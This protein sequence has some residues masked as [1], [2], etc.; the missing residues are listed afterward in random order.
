MRR[1]LLIE[2]PYVKSID[3]E[4]EAFVKRE[5]KG[6]SPIIITSGKVNYALATLFLT[7]PTFLFYPLTTH[8]ISFY[9]TDRSALVLNFK[10]RSLPAKEVVRESTRLKHMQAQRA[11]VKERSPVKVEVFLGNRVIYSKVF[12]PRGIRKD[13]AIFIYDELF[14]K[15]EG[16]KTKDKVGRISTQG[17]GKGVGV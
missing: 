3:E 2:A 6:E 8:K 13:A 9:P 1:Y 10:Y 12:N 4:I 15:P 16:Q 17:K 5:K 11:I 7:I 14:F